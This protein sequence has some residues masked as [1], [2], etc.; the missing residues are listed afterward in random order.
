MDRT[1][2]IR[3]GH[4]AMDRTHVSHQ[5]VDTLQWTEHSL[6]QGWTYC[7][8]QNTVSY[9][10]GHTA[11]DRTQSHIRGGHTAMDRTHV[12]HQGDTLQWTEHSLI[13][14]WTYCNGQNTV[15]HQGWTYCNGQNTVSY[16]GWTYCNGQ[17]TVSH[18]GW[19]YCNGQN[20]RLT[21]GVDILQWTEQGLIQGWTYCNGQNTRLPY[22]PT[23]HFLTSNDNTLTHRA[24]TNSLHSPNN[25]VARFALPRCRCHISLDRSHILTGNSGSP[26]FLPSPVQC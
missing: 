1:Q 8:G 5:G 4:T 11:M 23:S 20:T 12:S 24:S 7:N 14:G 21:S 22:R 13:Q 3:G 17:N 2:S 16:Q 19:T 26:Q 15:S 18:Q 10:G 6:I 25:A 9:R